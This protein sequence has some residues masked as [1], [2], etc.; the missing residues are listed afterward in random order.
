VLAVVI[1]SYTEF[2]AVKGKRPETDTKRKQKRRGK[3][4]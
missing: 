1:A 2:L 4:R 3:L